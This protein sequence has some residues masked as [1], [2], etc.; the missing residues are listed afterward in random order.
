[1]ND[2]QLEALKRFIASMDG[3]VVAQAELKAYGNAYE[4]L[5]DYV[6]DQLI[7]QLSLSPRQLHPG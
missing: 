7:E 2:K 5:T 3:D 1:M 4:H 6:A